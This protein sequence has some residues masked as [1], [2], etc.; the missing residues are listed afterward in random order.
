MYADRCGVLEMAVFTHAS[1]EEGRY[2]LGHRTA[3]SLR[4]NWVVEEVGDGM[5]ERG[6]WWEGFGG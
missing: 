2:R 6:Y 3:H 4:T 5:D 1:M